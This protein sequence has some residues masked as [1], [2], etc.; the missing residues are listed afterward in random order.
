MVS[1]QYKYGDQPLEGYTIQ[2]AA[3]R[4]GFGEVY[5]A[6]SE[7]GRQVALKEI[8]NYEQ[9]E[10][11]GISQCM[12]LK[13]PHLVTIFDV[14]HN[15]QGKPFVIM[16]F[17][18]GPSLRDL[19]QE[20]PGG[21]GEQ[22]SAFFLREIAKGL[23]FLHDCGIVHR[24]L[25][26]GNIF[27]ENGYVKIGDYG[28]SKLI[29]TGTH[30]E[31]TITVGTVHYMAPEIGAG[32]YDR[33]IDIYALGVLVYEM[34]TGEV[35]F[36][37]SSP[38]EI[39]MKHMTKE[40]DLSNI[41]EPFVRVIRRA[42]AKNPK[43][44]YQTVRE[45]VEDVFGS[46]NIR[47]SVSQFS[48][49]SL[50][51][52]AGKVAGKANIATPPPVPPKVPPMPSDQ[53]RSADNRINWDD[54]G[55]KV[56]AIGARVEAAGERIGK[57]GERVAHDISG[58]FQGPFRKKRPRHPYALASAYDPITPA[59]RR[60][61][62]FITAVVV[63]FGIGIFGHRDPFHMGLTGF[64]MIGGASF[65]IL[66]ARWR[67]FVTLESSA[68][69]NFIAT[70]FGILFAVLMSW[71]FALD[72]SHSENTFICLIVLAFMNW[73][74]ITAP[75]RKVRVALGHAVALGAMGFFAALL[76][77][78]GLGIHTLT[79]LVMGV[80]AGTT[81]VVQISSPYIPVEARADFNALKPYVPPEPA[82][83]EPAGAPPSPTTPAYPGAHQ[84][85]H[86]GHHPTAPSA[87]NGKLRAVPTWMRMLWLVG[88]IFLLGTAMTL[89]ICAGVVNMSDDDIALTIGF[90]IGSL[91]FAFFC[92]MKSFGRF[93]SG[94]YSYLIK[95]VLLLAMAQIIFISSM[96]LGMMNLL[97][98][99]T[100]I[101]LIFIIF[102]SI[103]A[104]VLLFLPNRLIEGPINKLQ[105]NYTALY[106][107]QAISP[108]KRV[109]ALLLS[110]IFF[111]VGVGGLQRF[112]VGKIGTG[113]L[114][115]VTFGCFGIGQLIDVI[116][117]L[118]GNFRDKDG[119]VLKIWESERELKDI[120]KPMAINNTNGTNGTTEAAGEQKN[121]APQE[122]TS[123]TPLPKSD[124]L[125]GASSQVIMNRESAD[126]AGYLFAS[127]GTIF[128]VLGFLMGLVLA[129][130]VPA[131]MAAGVFDPDLAEE[132]D[133]LFDGPGWP[134]IL[135]RM[136]FVITTIFF[137]LALTLFIIARRKFG[138]AHLV[139]AA[140]GIG[141]FLISLVLLGDSIPERYTPEINRLITQEEIGRALNM[142]FMQSK[143]DP[144]IMAAVFFV[145]SLIVLSWPPA[146]RK[147]ALPTG[148]ANGI[149]VPFD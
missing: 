124:P 69:R 79:P 20:A 105:M 135:E 106:N 48:P 102:P 58:G 2:R 81:L 122:Q 141:G 115:L 19:L 95:P 23:S 33:C 50:S 68:P 60:I 12:N 93:Y 54:M 134:S 132:L 72:N 1:Y 32:C 90:G 73:W 112:Y 121:G 104:L 77:D 21:L 67:L 61:L 83:Q 17:V 128:M 37:G 31:Q 51:V 70:V 7:G 36:F 117:I 47:N 88:F 85:F 29:N 94:W 66:L 41:G 89:L 130:H 142:I 111:F 101:A 5:Y 131:L 4:G 103:T 16:E 147:S 26:P 28:L 25:K 14:K 53:N 15:A 39:L 57:V 86:N 139:R 74:K 63:A 82:G 75:D 145:I 109:W 118:A 87:L 62:A 148:P 143:E 99:E 13:S 80:L 144:A 52:V 35:P 55:Q 110:G 9:I 10:L 137:L 100:A 38:S 133:K 92:L 149:G 91:L 76:M 43:D 18:S 129:F 11:R 71:P 84:P 27:Y 22:K 138:A 8:Q 46:E 113:I 114:W 3:G 126:L 146:G 125:S 45:M 140:L 107:N 116:M 40:P 34:L 56:A 78:E 30:S 24:D 6:L 108:Y 136:G 49:E 98:D 96:C 42:M 64:L 123:P 59:Q 97:G 44:R 127:L 119:R 65:G 120:I